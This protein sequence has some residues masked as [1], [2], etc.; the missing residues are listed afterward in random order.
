M[1]KPS[2]SVKSVIALI[3]LTCLTCYCY[4]QSFTGSI[5]SAYQESKN[6]NYSVQWSVG[7]LITETFIANTFKVGSGTTGIVALTITGISPET[8]YPNAVNTFPNPF[9]ET[10]TV[11]SETISLNQSAF[12]FYN[13]LGKKQDVSIVTVQ[14]NRVDFATHGMPSGFYVLKIKN[15]STNLLI[16]VIRE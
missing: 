9:V 13:A 15:N 6:S 5:V 1:S 16:K 11:E 12:E 4:S 10:L 8:S 3:V 7:D 2:T 14:R